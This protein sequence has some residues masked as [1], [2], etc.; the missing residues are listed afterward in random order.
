MALDYAEQ[1]IYSVTTTVE[2]LL[3]YAINTGIGVFSPHI[4]ADWEHEYSDDND[5]I[6]AKF[7]NGGSFEEAIA[8]NVIIIP[9]ENPDTDFYNLGLG[10]ATT[11]P[12]GISAFV[13]YTTILGLKDLT[14]HQLIGGVRFEF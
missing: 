2:M 5:D 14:Y 7:V 11:F 9:T 12:Y 1:D 6:E 3:S 4:R 8:N 10:T 13:D